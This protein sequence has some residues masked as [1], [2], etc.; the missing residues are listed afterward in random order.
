M[1]RESQPVLLPS[2][3][4][5]IKQKLI[6]GKEDA[7]ISSWHRLLSELKSE[8][9]LIRNAGQDAIPS[10]SYGDLANATRVE[11]FATI[12]KK[13]GAGIVRGVVC[14][15]VAQAWLNE[16][17][18]YVSYNSSE[19]FAP[20]HQDHD[21][22]WSPAQVRAR[23]H[24]R[25]LETQRLLLN[26]WHTSEDDPLTTDYPI[27]YADRL[28]MTCPE[29]MNGQQNPIAHLS[30]AGAERWDPDARAPAYQEIW[31]SN[32]EDYDPW[33]SRKRLNITPNL[34]NS[35]GACS[36]VQMWQ[37]LFCLDT[38]SSGPGPV[39]LCPM[40][41]L[42]TAYTSLRPFFTP[43]NTCAENPNFLSPDNWTFQAPASSILHGAVPAQ[44]QSISD[45]LHPHLQLR[46]TLISLP[47]LQ[48]GDYLVFHPDTIFAPQPSPS[49]VM[50]LPICPLTR[51]N[52]LYL[53]RQRKAFLLGQPP[54]DF[55]QT[56]RDHDSRWAGRLGV[57]EISDTGGVEALRAMGL[58]PWDED[59]VEGIMEAE[60]LEDAN[61][62]LFPD[63]YDFDV[64]GV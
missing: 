53:L 34:Y 18:Q 42:S 32:W 28:H 2:R 12:L 54:P 51:T 14:E 22:F 45:I 24:P 59:D 21:I 20:R 40:L 13:R 43:R 57:Q 5:T 47:P 44:G 27:V 33:A 60:V 29:S 39:R 48:P 7:I 41:L 55:Q 62:V 61:N 56:S 19:N 36:A 38:N 4:A 6:E 35:T 46:D 23:A 52:A 10:I 37:G 1:S 25:V 17:Q 8:I 58:A 3:F 49:T 63:R 50:S 9:D 26:L 64:D 31:D 30:G 16:T 11:S 15:D